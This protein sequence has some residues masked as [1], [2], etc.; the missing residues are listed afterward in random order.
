MNLATTRLSLREMTWDDL[1]LIHQLHSMKEVEE[2]S[3]IGIPRHSG[4][5]LAVMLAAIEDPASAH[6]MHFGWTVWITDT[7]EFIGEAGLDLSGDRF[8]SGELFYSLSPAQWGQGY[9]TEIVKRLI[10][11][12][13]SE[14]RLHR[15]HA[16]VAT[17]NLRSIKVLEK[18]GMTCEG[19]RR[20]A[21][22][23]RGQWKDKFSYAIVEDDPF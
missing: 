5:T 18:A 14:L 22:P 6:R 3:T 20:K 7:Q 13:F 12:G 16:G 9:G 23:I 4:D 8:N 2:F 19:I 1:D 10:S 15:I 21:L 17:D 11:F